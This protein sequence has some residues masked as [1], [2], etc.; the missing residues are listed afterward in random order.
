M[1]VTAEDLRRVRAAVGRFAASVGVGAV[2]LGMV[3]VV[4]AELSTNAVRH[5]G[6][7]GWC[8][9]WYRRGRLFVQVSNP[10]RGRIDPV[11]GHVGPPLLSEG[12]RGLWMVRMFAERLLI[13]PNISGT[14]I[15][16][17]VLG[18]TP[19]VPAPGADHAPPGE[20]AAGYESAGG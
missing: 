1:M 8:R 3:A 17:A 13:L 18:V 7:L 5:G 16:T 6:G 4:V 20:V 12:G 19:E 11:A 14:T 9:A 10:A 2:R 15:V